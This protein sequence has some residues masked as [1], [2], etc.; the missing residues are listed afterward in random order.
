ML[1]VAVKRFLKTTFHIPDNDYLI[2][3]NL[4]EAEF[5]NLTWEKFQVLQMELF[6][7]EQSLA[8]PAI[9]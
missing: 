9:F 8:C 5:V 2:P 4:L 1:S 3:R 6:I 7:T